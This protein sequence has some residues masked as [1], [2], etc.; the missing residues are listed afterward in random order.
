ME[1]ERRNKLYRGQTKHGERERKSLGARERERE[2]KDEEVAGKEVRGANG[3]TTGLYIHT[4]CLCFNG[5][6]V[7]VSCC[8]DLLHIFLPLKGGGRTR[9]ETTEKQ[10]GRR[11]RASEQALLLFSTL[12]SCLS[13]QF[14]HTQRA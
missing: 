14:W 11:V 2:I 10:S 9:N 7:H 1:I 13:C 6:M 5:I 4:R 8:L 3:G 12:R